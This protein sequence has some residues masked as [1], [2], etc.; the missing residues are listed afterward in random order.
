[1]ERV[2][3]ATP[4]YWAKFYSHILNIRMSKSTI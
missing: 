2:P 3:V 4:S 1:M